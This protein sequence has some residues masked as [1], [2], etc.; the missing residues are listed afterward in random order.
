MLGENLQHLGHQRR[1]SEHRNAVHSVVEPTLKKA[2]MRIFF[3]V[4]VYPLAYMEMMETVVAHGHK[5][6]TVE[7]RLLLRLVYN[8]LRKR[9]LYFCFIKSY[10][11]SQTELAG[12]IPLFK[13]KRVS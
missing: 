4:L 5:C 9:N 3:E 12:H 2:L 13:R 11:Q 7:P 1:R 8:P 6:S 10:F